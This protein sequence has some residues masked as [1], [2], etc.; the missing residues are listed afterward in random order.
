MK[1]LKLYAVIFLLVFHCSC[2]ES[3]QVLKPLLSLDIPALLN[4]ELHNLDSN[5]FFSKELLVQG[6][7][8]RVQ[9]SYADLKTLVKQF[10]EHDLRK[11]AYRNAYHLDSSALVEHY[12]EIENRYALK[13]V[14]LQKDHD[15][16]IHMYIDE[17]NQ[18]YS[19]RQV[20]Q[21][22]LQQSISIFKINDVQ[23]MKPDTFFIRI[24][25]HDPISR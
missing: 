6:K 10:S 22:K 18:L 5:Q 12:Q 13:S 9:I 24:N 2:S 7:Y 15:S 20:V 11:P 17:T 3:E 23:G 19:S 4:K 1:N 21:W 14:Y 25:F 16:S 8:E